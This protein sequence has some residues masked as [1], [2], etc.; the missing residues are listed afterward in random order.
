[1]AQI[2]ERLAALGTSFSQI[3]LADERDYALFLDG[4]D[5]LA[6]LSESLVSSMRSAAEERGQAQ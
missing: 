1:M 4:P 6:G 2:D 3:V 5:D